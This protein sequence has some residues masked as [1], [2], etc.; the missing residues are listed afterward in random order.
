MY[1]G[2]LLLS[3]YDISMGNFCIFI[4]KWSFFFVCPTFSFLFFSLTKQEN[5][6]SWS[7]LF[8]FICPILYCLLLH[9]N[10]KHLWLFSFWGH[11]YLASMRELYWKKCSC[12][13]YW[14]STSGRKCVE[15]NEYNLLYA[16]FS[17]VML[18]KYWLF[19]CVWWHEDQGSTSELSINSCFFSSTQ[20]GH[21]LFTKKVLQD[22]WTAWCTLPYEGKQ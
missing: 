18:E 7:A 2:P 19:L 9:M 22:S 16:I 17:I 14:L 13:S 15:Y 10:V 11:S 20:F 6:V 5:C 3:L 12:S 1:K 21:S 8:I 4:F